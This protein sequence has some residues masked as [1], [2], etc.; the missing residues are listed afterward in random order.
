MAKCNYC[1]VDPRD[2]HPDKN[3]GTGTCSKC[4]G[5]PSAWTTC[6]G[7]KGMSGKCV[8]CRGSGVR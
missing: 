5:K 6:S 3:R 7:C 1:W 2:R 4:N 8:P